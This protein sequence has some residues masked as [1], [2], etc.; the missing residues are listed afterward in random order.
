M[1]IKKD[2]LF[3]ISVGSAFLL[4]AAFAYLLHFY[5]G[6]FRPSASI[7]QTNSIDSGQTLEID[8]SFPV[9]TQTIEKISPFFLKQDFQ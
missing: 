6:A 1:D 5:P 9:V 2:L 8:F 7:R 3:L 4:L